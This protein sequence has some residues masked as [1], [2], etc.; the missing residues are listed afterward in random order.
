MSS[1]QSWLNLSDEVRQCRLCAKQ[2]PLGPQPIFSGSPTARLAII[3]QA[4]GRRAH[5]A[6]I[7]F[8]DASGNRL[9]SWLDL[10]GEAFYDSTRIAIMP[11]GFCYPGTGQGGDMLPNPICA[12]TWHKPLRA[13]MQKLDLTLLVGGLAQKAYLQNFSNVTQVVSEA[14]EA[15]GSMVPLPHPS[16]HNN[17]W[18]KHHPWFESEMLPPL[19]ERIAKLTKILP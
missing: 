17:A 12:T 10:D 6:G 19:R 8:A 1:F 18:L 5:L 3:G 9:R 15:R 11:M 13:A 16:W 2:L 14:R 4:P 7:P